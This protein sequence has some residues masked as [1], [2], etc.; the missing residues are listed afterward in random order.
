MEGLVKFEEHKL[1]EHINVKKSVREIYN[2]NN[3]LKIKDT[4]DKNTV[5]KQIHV[6]INYSILDKGINLEPTEINYIKTRVVDDIMRDFSHLSVD[7]IRLAFY[8][9]VRGEFG[10]YYGIN[11][12]TFYNWIKSYRLE[13]LP[14]VYLEVKPLLTTKEKIEEFN[15]K[16]LDFDLASNLVRAYSDFCTNGNHNLFDMGNIHYNFLVRMKLISLT[17]DEY[18]ESKNKAIGQIKLRVA[19]N[20]SN[21]RRQG[22]QYH[23]INNLND[24]FRQIEKV[25]KDYKVLIKAELKRI[26]LDKILEKFKIENRDLTQ[27]FNNKIDTYIYE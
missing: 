22:K 4:S 8:Y 27:L 26:I 23:L 11:P 3:S 19:E 25:D 14:K 1:P 13:L 21:L 7:D 2:A 9:G 15:Q 6:F 16:K 12:I 18:I 20:N 10:E 17:R 5:V 24:V